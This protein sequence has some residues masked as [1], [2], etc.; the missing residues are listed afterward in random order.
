MIYEAAFTIFSNNTLRHYFNVFSMTFFLDGKLM[1][2]TT[3]GAV[4]RI[5]DAYDGKPMHTLAGFQNN[6][7]SLSIPPQ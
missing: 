2:L 7:A 6:K 3:N 1:M 4:I 5:V